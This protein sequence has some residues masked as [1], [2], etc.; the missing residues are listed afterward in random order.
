[1]KDWP[2]LSWTGALLKERAGQRMI[3]V[4]RAHKGIHF[5]GE[6][7][8]I[9]Y[10]PMQLDAFVDELTSGESR[11]GKLYAALVPILPALPELAEDVRFPPYFER[12]HCTTANLWYGP[13]GSVSPLHYDTQPNLLC[14]LRGRKTVHLYAPEEIDNLY[15]FPFHRPWMHISQVNVTQPDLAR[16]PKYENAKKLVAELEPGDMLHIPLFYWHAVFSEPGE[17]LSLNYWWQTPPLDYLRHPRQTARGLGQL[18]IS[19]AFAKRHR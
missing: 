12:S 5:E 14:Q 4:S 3:R 7:K 8:I 6:S 19:T 13:G 17:N 10:Q 11:D 2:A 15:P 16:F 9:D 1:M 18:V